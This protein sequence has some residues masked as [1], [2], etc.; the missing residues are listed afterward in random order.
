MHKEEKDA[1]QFLFEY[2]AKNIAFEKKHAIKVKTTLPV[3]T[4]LLETLPIVFKISQQ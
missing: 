2:D 3:Q 1:Y 4:F